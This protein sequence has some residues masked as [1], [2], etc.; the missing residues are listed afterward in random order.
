MDRKRGDDF[1]VAKIKRRLEHDCPYVLYPLG[2]GLP[3]CGYKIIKEHRLAEARLNDF[4]MCDK[5]NCPKDRAA[6]GG[7]IF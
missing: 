5:K 4:P 2:N 7:R 1:I 6:K 3:L